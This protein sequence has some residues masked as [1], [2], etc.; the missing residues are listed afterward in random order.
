MVSMFEYFRS[1][2]VKNQVQNWYLLV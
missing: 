1:M 2:I